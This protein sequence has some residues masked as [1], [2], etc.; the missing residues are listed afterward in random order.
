[1]SE[2]ENIIPSEDEIT[3]VLDQYDAWLQEEYEKHGNRDHAIDAATEKVAQSPSSKIFFWVA[4][5][6]NS[7]IYDVD[8]TLDS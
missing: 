2:I 4:D 8:D 3:D 7:R 6:D 5:N 1:M